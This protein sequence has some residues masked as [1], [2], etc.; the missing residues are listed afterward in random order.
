VKRAPNPWADIDAAKAAWEAERRS[1]DEKLVELG[2]KQRTR[3]D[4]RV[5]LVTIDERGV[6]AAK[7][8]RLEELKAELATGGAR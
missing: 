7:A 1:L 4:L 6:L 2:V 8:E 5:P 3:N